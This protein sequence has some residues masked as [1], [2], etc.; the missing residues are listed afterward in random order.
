[1]VW[2]LA[3]GEYKRVNSGCQAHNS[4]QSAHLFVN[5]ILVGSIL[6]GKAIVHT[7]VLFITLRKVENFLKY[8]SL[9]IRES[10]CVLML[11]L[12]IAY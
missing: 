9:V 10:Y 12:V 1:M 2:L 7:Y 3:D 5:C 8:A 4:G 11:L 6:S